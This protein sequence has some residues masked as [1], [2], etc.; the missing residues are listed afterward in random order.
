M[1]ECL[2]RR[3]FHSSWL[4]RER[5]NLKTSWKVWCN[6]TNKALLLQDGKTF[7][8]SKYC[9]LKCYK[10]WVVYA[11]SATQTL[12]TD[13][14]MLASSLPDLPI[15]WTSGEAWLHSLPT[16]TKN[17]SRFL[18]MTLVIT[19]CIRVTLNN[20]TSQFFQPCHML[21]HT[22]FWFIWNFHCHKH[23]TKEKIFK[24]F[25]LLIFTDYTE[26]LNLNNMH[27]RY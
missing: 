14:S 18:S 8:S 21:Q 20:Q 1:T 24:M 9:S 15:G 2:I 16:P 27:G 22:L 12:G 4:I 19:T 11:I 23:N 7:L 13:T 26:H 25:Y 10:I 3:V 6:F 17:E 5:C